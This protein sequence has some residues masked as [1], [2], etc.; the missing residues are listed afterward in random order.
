MDNDAQ[1]DEILD[2]TL[3]FLRSDLKIEV[4]PRDF[5]N[6]LNSLMK[7]L[8]VITD[9]PVDSRMVPVDYEI[10]NTI[11]HHKFDLDE[12]VAKICSVAEEWNRTKDN[13]KLKEEEK[14]I[15]PY[16][17]FIQSSGMGKTKLMYEFAQL[18]RREDKNN[19]VCKAVS[20]D[21][22]LSS[23]GILVPNEGV[24][25]F[26]LDLRMFE[27]EELKQDATT[28]AKNIYARLENKLVSNR[29]KNELVP[30]KTTHVFLF[31]EAQ[32]LLK[33]HYGFEAFLFRCIRK[34]LRTKR[35]GIT[36][37]G[38]FSG[39]SSAI[40]NYTI[41][42]DL[43]KDDDLE[44]VPPSRELQDDDNYYLRGLRTFEPFV[45]LTTMAVLKPT[46]ESQNLSCDET[47]YAK[48]IR[49]GRPLF[50]V[51]HENTDLRE[52]ID[53]ILGRL[54][55]QTRKKEVLDWTQ[56]PESMLSVLATRVQMGSTNL[57]VVSELVAKGYAN[58]TGVTTNFATFAYMPD[59]VCARLAMCMMDET[60]KFLK[61]QGKPKQWWS[62]AVKTLFST[63][64]RL[65]TKGDLG[66]VLTALYFLFCGD[67][68]R[69]TIDVNKEYTTF[70]VILEDWMNS[71]L[72]EKIGSE[73][74]GT[75]QCEYRE[76]SSSQS[77][78]AGK[79]QN[80]FLL[81]FESISSKSFAIT[82][83]HHGVDWRIKAS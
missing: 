21:L 75:Q 83:G 38:V 33:T 55:L 11:L 20:C 63:G 71:L 62:D 22:I 9:V 18:T 41:Q 78:S 47:D 48:S 44:E 5:T 49:Y 6:A 50:A 58:L 19:D 43:L 64:L 8:R 40:M 77:E 56:R 70:S 76:K 74:D 57:S 51:M 14:Y 23:A 37:I 65:P 73:S 66:E 39:T 28:T 16:F 67:E 46:N 3:T 2:G 42:T 25:D 7:E 10:T 72:I 32:V 26:K 31:D 1:R 80:N 79:Q 35:D 15:A 17:C 34:W 82:R 29:E 81:E 53:T 4:K 45:T 59:P 24:F 54:L 36:T 60:W 12:F 68:C 27:R 52:N 13:S 30:M 61:Y 69:K